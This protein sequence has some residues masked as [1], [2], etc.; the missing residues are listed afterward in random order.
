MTQKTNIGNQGFTLPMPQAILGTRHN[1]RPNYMALGWVIRVNFKPPLIGVSVNKAHA[2]HEA[3]R[4]TGQFS[5]N[6]PSRNMVEVTDYVGLVSGAN[7]DKSDLFEAEYGELAD[8]PLITA[9]PLS[10]ACR[11]YET[12]ELPTNTFFIGEILGTYCEE[13]FMT[14]G[15]PD[16][17]KIAPFV[18]TMPDNRFWAIGECVGQAWKSGK[19]LKK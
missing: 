3:I 19:G 6:F 18:L 10:M 13:R 4:D 12:V 14:D 9:C 5:I 17:E 11:V 1:G 16:I 7:V 8:A 2:S 15:S